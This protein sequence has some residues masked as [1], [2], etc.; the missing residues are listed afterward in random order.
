MNALIIILTLAGL[1]DP[2]SFTIALQDTPDGLLCTDGRHAGLYIAD[3]EGELE[4]LSLQPGAGH[5]VIFSD[6]GFLFKECPSGR[7]QRVIN[8]T[9][10]GDRLVLFEGDYFSGPFVCTRST[11][12]IAERG[13]ITEYGIHGEELRSWPAGSFP[14]WVACTGGSIFYTGETG[15]LGMLDIL[16][17]ELSEISGCGQTTFSRIVAG[18]KG[19]LLAEKSQGGF[20]VLDTAGKVILE[21]STGFFPS[22]TDEGNVLFSYLEFEGMYPVSGSILSIDPFT[23]TECT[24]E[25]QVVSLYPVEL[26]NGSIIWTDAGNGNVNGINM[27]SLPCHRMNF[28]T[29]DPDAHFD[30]SYM[31]Q[32]WDT[33]DWFNG[34]WSCGPTSCMMAVQYYMMLTPDSIW[35]SYPS[36]GHWSMWGNYIPVEY[37]FLGYLYDEL[38]ESPGGVMV[39]G[40]HGFIC[41][42]GSAVWNNMVVFLNRHE[43]SSAWAGTSWSTLTGQIDSNYPVV[44]SSTVLGYG[45]IILLNGYYSNHTVV[46][47]DPFGDA[48]ES[49]WGSYYNGKDVLYD[50]PGYNN[51]HVQIGVSQLFYAQAGVPSDPDT[52]VDDRCRGF[53]RYADCRFWHLAGSGYNGNAW[54]TYSTGALPD[55]CIA[56]WYPALPFEGDY[57]VYVYI[58]PAYASATGIYKLQTSAG[59]E[60]INLDQGS[61]SEQWALLGTFDLDYDSYLKLGDY[62]GTGG[63]YIAFDAALFR[64]NGTGVSREESVS[65]SQDLRLWPNPC[66]ELVSILLPSTNEG[67]LIEVYD[68]SGRMVLNTAAFE[69]TETIQLDISSFAAGLYLLRISVFGTGD[70]TFSRLLTVCR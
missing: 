63:Q 11:F 2:S 69:Y 7:P 47:N 29:D 57:D 22:W 50:W 41:P 30:V 35:A 68:T 32:R 38:G 58:P 3:S 40:A 42:N 66:G 15:G 48:N 43:V 61:Y 60:E 1:P 21:N 17:G 23:G 70:S 4:I 6:E 13:R 65:Q 49:G 55:T 53:Y 25:Q 28:S 67:V 51:G 59:M 8:I 45:H 19:M 26:E 12:L 54:W 9:D 62:T 10:E 14:A 20:A 27:T 46:V 18:P 5:N 44:C 34:S 24:L 36:P 56:E 39:P 52:L 31:H 33:P 37:T 64:P 16:S